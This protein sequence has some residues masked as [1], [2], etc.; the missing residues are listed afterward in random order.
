RE[1]IVGL[2]P[3]HFEDAALVG[4]APG[5]TIKVPIDLVE[6][7]GSDVYA[8]FTVRGEAHSGDLEDL[9][10]DAGQ[11]MHGHGTQVN[12]RLDAA[13]NVRAGMEATLWV[14]TGKMAVFDVGTGLNLT[15]E[16]ASTHSAV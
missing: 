1:V 9:A 11:D 16:S 5:A 15:A 7:M 2:R 14:D 6:S 8:Y 10:K 4:S 12:A 3:E 13:A